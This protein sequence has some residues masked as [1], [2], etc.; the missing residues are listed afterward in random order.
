MHAEVA[1][2]SKCCQLLRLDYKYMDKCNVF[3]P[4]EKEMKKW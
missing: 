1:I 4:L 3:L 2:L